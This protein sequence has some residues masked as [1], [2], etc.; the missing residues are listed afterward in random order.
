[1]EDWREYGQGEP[2]KLTLPQ[3]K[4]VEPGRLPNHY[5]RSMPSV[6]EFVYQHTVMQ[7]IKNN[8][9]TPLGATLAHNV[10]RSRMVCDRVTWTLYDAESG[11]DGSNYTQLEVRI[12]PVSDYTVIA[13][14]DTQSNPAVG[15]LITQD[16]YVPMDPGVLLWAY[17]TRTGTGSVA[18]NNKLCVVTLDLIAE[19]LP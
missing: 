1:M 9:G 3:R 4:P 13:T 11:A 10:T 5:G 18:Y 6:A 16:C 12:G 19:R 8:S 15:D 7:Q 14:L 2:N 17:W